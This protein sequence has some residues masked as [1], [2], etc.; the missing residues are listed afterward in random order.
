MRPCSHRLLAIGAALGLAVPALVVSQAG[1]ALAAGCP[2]PAASA[3]TTA[4]ATAP[5]TVALTFDD[6]PGPFTPLILKV[7]RE[8]GVRATFFDTGAHDAAF[9]AFTRAITADGNLLEDHSWDHLYPSQVAGGWTTAY[10]QDQIARTAAQ[11]TALTGQTVC[12]F[13]P[14]GGFTTNVLT[15]AHNLGVSEELW[16]ID[17]SDWKQPGFVS[18]PE[19][20]AIVAAATATG[21][22][23]HPVVLMH[24]AKASHEPDSQVSPFRGNTVAALPA[25]I[26]WYRANGY[27][28][29]D[30]AGGSGLRGRTTDFSGDQLGDVLATRPDGSLW[31]YLGNGASGWRSAVP[32]GTGW[33]GVDAMTSAGDFAGNGHPALLYRQ[34]ADGSLRMYTTTGAGGWGAS[35]QIG[36][37]WDVCSAIFSPGDFDSDGHPDVMCLRADDGTLWL[38]PGNGAGG[39][40]APA[41]VGTGF[42][43]YERILGPGDFDGDGYP[44]VLAVGPDGSLVLFSGNGSGGW[45][46]QRQVGTG[47]QDFPRVFSAGDFTGDGWPD[48]L[49]QRSDGTLQLYVGNGTGGWA[50]QQ[51]VGTG[52]NALTLVAGMG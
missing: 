20:D 2:P 17:T 50:G 47:W 15:A 45:R 5:R 46:S 25:I 41:R 8:N 44:D 9:P 34:R 10:V 14:P 18:Q 42:A 4:P 12:W 32:V 40:R 21:G 30:L 6:G 3:V 39:F 23:Q 24:A 51:Q 26:A 27:Q 36:T 31:A 43:G 7:L 13:R 28:F 19:V 52:W 1:T 16:S 22:Q 11:Q 33:Q 48:V 49:G 38:Y 37:A 35:R 29:V